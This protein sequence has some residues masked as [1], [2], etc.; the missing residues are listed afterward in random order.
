MTVKE[1]RDKLNKIDNTEILDKEIYLV[2]DDRNIV[3]KIVELCEDE[4]T[5]NHDPDEADIIFEEVWGQVCSLLTGKLTSCVIR[6][7]LFDVDYENA[8][9]CFLSESDY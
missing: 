4:F 2:L 3:D 8:K 9:I 1:L 5:I 7:D 6:N